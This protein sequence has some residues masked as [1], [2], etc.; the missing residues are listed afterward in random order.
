MQ[1]PSASRCRTRCAPPLIFVAISFLYTVFAIA[2]LHIPGYNVLADMRF[3]CLHTYIQ[4]LLEQL[5]N[6]Q[7][8]VCL[9]SW[10]NSSLQLHKEFFGTC[11][12]LDVRILEWC[13]LLNLTTYVW[14]Q[15]CDEKCDTVYYQK[16]AK[17][18]VPDY[19]CENVCVPAEAPTQHCYCMN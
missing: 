6:I 12:Q 14:L 10:P 7:S 1:T 18:C 9:S 17:Q 3:T 4:V 5:P 15:A 16:C 2:F 19:T 13:T 11:L 8:G